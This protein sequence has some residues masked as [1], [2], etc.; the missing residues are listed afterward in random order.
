M[1]KNSLLNP[2]L[3]LALFALPFSNLPSPVA[4]YVPKMGNGLSGA[5]QRCVS[6]NNHTFS[7]Q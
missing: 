5:P 2:S 1:F 4:S 7:F 3:M 6:A